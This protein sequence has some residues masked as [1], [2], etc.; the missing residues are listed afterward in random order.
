MVKTWRRLRRLRA[1]TPSWVQILLAIALLVA[2]ALL[3]FAMTAVHPDRF[4]A[5]VAQALKEL[6]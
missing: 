6:S 3:V 2:A 5:V 4:A 1:R